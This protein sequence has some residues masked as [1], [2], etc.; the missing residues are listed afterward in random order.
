[1]SSSLPVPGSDYQH[2]SVSI[3]TK[4]LEK[5]QPRQQSA[6]DAIKNSDTYRQLDAAYRA[7]DKAVEAD[8]DKAVQQ[9][10]CV[11]RRGKSVIDDRFQSAR[12]EANAK[13]YEWEASGAPDTAAKVAAFKQK[14]APFKGKAPKEDGSGEEE[15]NYASYEDL[16]AEYNRL[17]WKDHKND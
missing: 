12:A 10:A 11:P 5:N 15:Y 6:E 14:L 3:Y 9:V 4:W 16:E 17:E 13:T 8:Y 2:R 7:A 1:M